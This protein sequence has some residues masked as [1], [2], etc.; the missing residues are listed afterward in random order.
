MVT[1][2]LTKVTEEIL[3]FR[4]GRDASTIIVC[5]LAL[6]EPHGLATPLMLSLNGLETVRG[7]RAANRKATMPSISLVLA[8][9]S[10]IKGSFRFF[11][12]PPS[13]SFLAPY[14][15][16]LSSMTA[17][18]ENSFD[19]TNKYDE[20][21]GT[22][23]FHWVRKHEGRDGSDMIVSFKSSHFP[24]FFGWVFG[25]CYYCPFA[26]V[27]SA[28]AGRASAGAGQCSTPSKSS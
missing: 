23:L 9:P 18:P 4:E 24:L 5:F 2:T 14:S 15:R 28:Q 26:L 20:G 12:V 21:S 16:L 6:C 17:A 11:V 7:E 1:R 25:C 13:L 3:T 10:H 27:S 22:R 8:V 19:Q